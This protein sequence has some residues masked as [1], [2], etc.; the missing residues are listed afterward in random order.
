MYFF[1]TFL[2]LNLLLNVFSFGENP[3]E[4]DSRPPL[5]F[6]IE[7]LIDQR[8]SFNESHNS[9]NYL[10]WF[11]EKANE[12]LTSPCYSVM[13]KTTPSKDK[14]NYL[15]LARFWWPNEKSEN[16][17][18]YVRKD[19]IIN[20]EI[21]D[22]AYDY[23]KKCKMT[24][25]C[26]NLSLAYFFTQDER[27]S[28]KAAEK[29]KTWFLNSETRMNSHLN[30]A[31]GIP[32]KVSGRLEGIIESSS[33]PL[34]FDMIKLLEGSIFWT[35]ND[36]KKLEEWVREYLNWLLTSPIGIEDAKQSNNQG[37]WYDFQV[38][39]F[40]L[41]TNQN[42]LAKEHLIKNVYPKLKNQFN[43]FYLQPHELTRTKSFFYSYYNLHAL[44]WCA[45]L[46]EH[47]KEDILWQ[48][49]TKDKS[50]LCMSLDKMLEYCVM[51]KKWVHDDIEPINPKILAP[52]LLIAATICQE[53]KYRFY[54]D[55]F[56]DHDIS[57]IPWTILYPIKVK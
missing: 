49:L 19:G 16:K 25:D 17:L 51:D 30:F 4:Y 46:G 10:N 38:I 7:D 35:I 9:S 54:H 32:G 2:V 29:I 42:L 39:F 20:P 13:E 55:L 27:Y 33:F 15:S 3:L 41:Y 40:A 50:I 12:A 45:V 57:D 1:T 26:Q 21:W 34:L 47:L 14:H 37:S 56:I 36:Q 22:D 6:N 53:P 28:E 11:I 18:P 52:L 43:S 44:F 23:K 5:L 8:N 48:N 31:Q 24:I